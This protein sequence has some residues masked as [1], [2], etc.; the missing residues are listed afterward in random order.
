M[1]E[2]VA[3]KFD[4]FLF[5]GKPLHIFR[6]MALQPSVTSDVGSNDYIWLEDL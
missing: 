5:F 1:G 2:I 3:R 6:E 4:V